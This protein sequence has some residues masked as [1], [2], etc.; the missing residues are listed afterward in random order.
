MDVLFTE[1]AAFSLIKLSIFCDLFFQLTIWELRNRMKDL[2]KIKKNKIKN[3]Q[4]TNN[5]TP[6]PIR[7]LMN[8]K[9]DEIDLICFLLLEIIILK[10]KLIAFQ[11][12]VF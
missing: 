1:F 2:K 5:I 8:T 12:F 7:N 4:T 3:K 6:Y 9:E 11:A 10:I